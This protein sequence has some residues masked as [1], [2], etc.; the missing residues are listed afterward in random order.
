MSSEVIEI[1]V[2]LICIQ[3]VYSYMLHHDVNDAKH[4]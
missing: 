1:F 2:Y 3:A 4:N